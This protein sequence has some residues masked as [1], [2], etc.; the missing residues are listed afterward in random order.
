MHRFCF[1]LSFLGLDYSLI[2]PWLQ[3]VDTADGMVLDAFQHPSKPGLWVYAVKLAG[4]LCHPPCAIEVV[5][6][7]IGIRMG[8]ALICLQMLAGVLRT[9]TGGERIPSGGWRC[10][11]SR[12]FISGIDPQASCCALCHCP[13][14]IARRWCRLSPGRRLRSNLPRGHEDG[15][16]R[17]H[18]IA[19]QTRADDLVHDV[20]ARHSQ[21]KYPPGTT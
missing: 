7:C 13:F 12:A 10:T 5:V 21:R 1:G 16:T 14:V 20:V 15:L 18:M 3:L 2:L 11:A 8:K 19:G 6:A 17:Q 4:H 9:P